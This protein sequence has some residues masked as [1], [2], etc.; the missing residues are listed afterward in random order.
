[1]FCPPVNHVCS[2]LKQS[3]QMWASSDPY[4]ATQSITVKYSCLGRGSPLLEQVTLWHLM[5]SRP[6]VT[7]FIQ[8][9]W[10]LLVHRWLCSNF[11]TRNGPCHL[12]FILLNV[13]CVNLIH[14]KNAHVPL[15][16]VQTHNI[17][18]SHHVTAWTEA[19]H[20]TTQVMPWDQTWTG[21]DQYQ[22]TAL[23]QPSHLYVALV[24]P[25]LYG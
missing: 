7:P 19:S 2:N 17:S 10:I 6:I 21:P 22:D 24:L 15:H 5:I 16:Q 23:L 11:T 4:P 14:E 25:G 3:A 8:L 9:H 18:A 20:L 13:M 1:M 12:C